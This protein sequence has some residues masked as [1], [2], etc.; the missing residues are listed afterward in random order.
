MVV[1]F[2]QRY[3]L[4]FTYR[5]SARGTLS[6]EFVI[7]CTLGEDVVFIYVVTYLQG[8]LYPYSTPHARE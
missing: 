5:P 2:L 7:V 1:I 4:W 3:S 6:T 8:E